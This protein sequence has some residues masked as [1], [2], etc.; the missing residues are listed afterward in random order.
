MI[1]V[2]TQ[3]TI[4]EATGFVGNFE[5]T[6]SQNGADISLKHGGVIVAV[7]AEEFKPTEYQYGQD[8]RVLTHLE[9]DA[10]IKQGDARVSGAKTAVFIQCVGSREPDRPYCSKVCC[11]H[12]VK[13]ALSLKKMN[14]DMDREMSEVPRVERSG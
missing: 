13:S 6:I 11:T 5:T 2:Y 4:K 12:T 10:A 14:P 8:E 7:G 3:S 9:L 1:D